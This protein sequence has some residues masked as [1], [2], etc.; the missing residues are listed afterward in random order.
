MH[1]MNVVPPSDL[2]KHTLVDHDH[3]RWRPPVAMAQRLS[4]GPAVETARSA[5]DLAVVRAELDRVAG[6]HVGAGALGL[7]DLTLK[8]GRRPRL[9]VKNRY[10]FALGAR[11][12]KI[13]GSGDVTV[14]KPVE[15]AVAGGFLPGSPHASRRFRRW[16]QQ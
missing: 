7:D 12:D 4:I 16:M 14:V 10:P 1:L 11:G 15:R 13:A 8:L 2:V 6:D 9:V 5:D 3:G